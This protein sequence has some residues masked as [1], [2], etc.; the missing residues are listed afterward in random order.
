M[1]GCAMIIDVDDD[2]IRRE[3]QVQ[4]TSYFCVYTYRYV[5]Y[6]CRKR[7]LVWECGR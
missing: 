6:M 4:G 3:Q 5:V 2:A 7:Y 1:T